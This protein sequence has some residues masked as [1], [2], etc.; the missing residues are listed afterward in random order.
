M[1]QRIQHHIYQESI[2]EPL[3]EVKQKSLL[4]I[5][6]AEAEN[7]AIEEIEAGSDV[8]RQ[9]RPEALEPEGALVRR[10]KQGRSDVPR[11]AAPL[12]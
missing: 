4:T 11:C 12:P 6:E 9:A 1:A 2:P 7:I 3:E 5:E 10:P 8:Q